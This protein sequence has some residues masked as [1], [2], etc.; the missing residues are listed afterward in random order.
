MS[1]IED[2]FVSEDIRRGGGLPFPSLLHP[3]Q[4]LLLIPQFVGS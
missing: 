1:W 2:A 4:Y 3:H